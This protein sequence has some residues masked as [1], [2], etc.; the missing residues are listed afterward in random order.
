MLAF[1]DSAFAASF[2]DLPAPLN[3]PGVIYYWAFATVMVILAVNMALAIVI[4]AFSFAHVRSNPTRPPPGLPHLCCNCRPRL[5]LRRR[6]SPPL[7]CCM[8]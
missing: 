7:Y 6:L 8:N 2:Y 1:Q 3:V 5:A 4:D